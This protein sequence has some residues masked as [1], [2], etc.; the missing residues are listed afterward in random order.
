M[1]DLESNTL[2]KT[3]DAIDAVIAE[4]KT[5]VKRGEML[6]RL[7][8]DQDFKE[9]I[10][11]SYIEEEAARLF[12][13]L[14]DPSGASPYTSEQIQRK[15]DSIRDFKGHVETIKMNAKRA[16]EEI[17]RE[18]VYRKEATAKFARDGE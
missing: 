2:N 8:I 14:I 17:L 10:L 1:N 15:L 12:Q 7:M 13:I 16:P 11:D 4:K 3:L 6:E 18:E 5:A 9:V